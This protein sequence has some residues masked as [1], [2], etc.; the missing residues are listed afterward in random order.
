MLENNTCDRCN[1]E[2]NTLLISY[3]NTDSI[4]PSCREKESKHELYEEAKRVEHNEV[5][6]GNMN[7]PG[8]G[9]PD[10]LK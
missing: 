3:F 2:S 7:F 9:L 8:I 10:D 1:L 5:L 6:N 4:C